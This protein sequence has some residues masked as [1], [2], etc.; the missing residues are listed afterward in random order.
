MSIPITRFL[1]STAMPTPSTYLIAPFSPLQSEYG[2]VFARF[3]C[4]NSVTFCNS[5]GIES[6]LE[7][8]FYPAKDN[9]FD[10]EQLKSIHGEGM[11]SYLNRHLHTNI[12]G[13]AGMNQRYGRSKTLDKLAHRFMNTVWK[14]RRCDGA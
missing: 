5:L 6:V 8:R 12:N 2:V 1:P 10:G 4:Q 14:E 11:T 9:D 3:N 13:M 7:Y